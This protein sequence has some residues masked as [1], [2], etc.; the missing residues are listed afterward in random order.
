MGSGMHFPSQFEATF[1]V[2]GTYTYRCLIHQGFM[3]GSITVG[4]T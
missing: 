2:P 3:G 1:P 4:G